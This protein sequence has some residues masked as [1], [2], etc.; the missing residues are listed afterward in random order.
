VDIDGGS[1]AP[2]LTVIGAGNWSNYPVPVVDPDESGDDTY[3]LKIVKVTDAGVASQLEV[4]TDYTYNFGTNTITIPE[5]ASGDTFKVYYSAGYYIS[6][7]DVWTDNDSDE[8]GVMADSCSIYLRSTNYLHQLQS[9]SV[10]ITFDRNDVREIGNKEVVLRGVRN[11]TVRITLGRILD[12]F[13][14]EEVLRGVAAGYD[15]IDVRKFLDNNILII[16]MYTDETK[17]TFLMGYAFKDL[18]PTG[19]DNGIPLNE[20]VTR[21]VTLEGEEG[22][23]SNVEATLDNY[24]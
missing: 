19:V 12:A 1:A 4:T 17:S 22:V 11:T 3:I 18:A 14:I 10:D 6:G 8:P 21:G 23:I 7:S 9:V 16:K 24:S 15:K 20:Y 2:G 5:S 13:T